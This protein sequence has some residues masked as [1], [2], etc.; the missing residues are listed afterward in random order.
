MR[1]PASVY[2]QWTL[3]QW[4]DHV[5][6][7]GVTSLSQWATSSRSSYNR[8]AT[9]GLQREVAARL[10]WKPKLENGGL[11]SMTDDDFVAGFRAKGVRTIS[12]MW[13]G[14]Q[15]WCELLRT[16]GRFDAVANRL[17]CR[18]VNQSHPVD[19]V[20]YYLERCRR[21]GD[22]AAW[23][24]LDRNAAEAARRNGLM[25]EIKKL[26]PKRPAKGYPSAG[27]YCRSLPE[28]AVARLLEAN[29]VKFVTQLPYPFTFPR[30]KRH[31][32]KADMYL[33]EVGA[34]VEIWTVPI[35]DTSAHFESYVVRRRFKTDMCERLN[36][37]LLSIESQILFRVDVEAYLAHA[38]AVL[39]SIGVKLAVQLDP[40]SALASPQ[41]E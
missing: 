35:S 31:L 15:H 11:R 3:E 13:R 22:L 23:A 5:R 17:G 28:L 40:F 6:E 14:A 2:R 25:D 7:L 16:Q 34:Y 41:P 36:L 8:A 10:G 26:A 37:R 20:S 4:C 12:D 30:G 21:A 18:Y 39:E 9:L 1:I 27:G 29:E 19:D 32:S 24:Q 33:T 38:S